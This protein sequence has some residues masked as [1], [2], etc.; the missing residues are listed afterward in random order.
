MNALTNA[1][2][3]LSSGSSTT[4]GV[5]WMPTNRIGGRMGHMEAEVALE[6]WT[7]CNNVNRSSSQLKSASEKPKRG[8]QYIKLLGQK[9]SKL[10]NRG[11][12]FLRVFLD[13]FRP[14]ENNSK[15]YLA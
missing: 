1:L 14:S 3:M 15:I 7:V 5:S 2:R 8:I 12:E 9:L 11:K 4:L 10:K 13:V 6:S